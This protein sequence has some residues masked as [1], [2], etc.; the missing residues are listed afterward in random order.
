MRIFNYHPVTGKFLGESVAEESPLEPGVFLVP[1]YATPIEP[2]ATAEGQADFFVNG[3]W[4][5][6][7][8]AVAGSGS[9]IPVSQ[10]EQILLQIEAIER[11]T[12]MNRAVREFMLIA[13][14]ERAAG[15][16]M[17]AE[18][19]YAANIAYR[20]VKDTDNRIAALRGQL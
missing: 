15:L 9:P 17:T 16:G 2:P 18:Q 8:D 6:L 1:A 11:E 20:R 19:L 3:E 10:R 4:V 7:D 12:L 14:E 5:V 13:S